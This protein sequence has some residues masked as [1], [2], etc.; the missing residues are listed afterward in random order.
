MREKKE[1]ETEQPVRRLPT[2]DGTWVLMR[3]KKE[4]ETE[5]PVRRLPT[6]GENRQESSGDAIYFER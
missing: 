1:G 2:S 3:Q 4:S 6:S 5:D